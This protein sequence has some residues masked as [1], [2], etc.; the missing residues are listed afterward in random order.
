VLHGATIPTLVPGSVP[1]VLLAGMKTATRRACAT[2][3]NTHRS[4][5]LCM[6]W[7]PAQQQMWWKQGG[8]R[9]PHCLSPSKG[10]QN[11]RRPR[12]C[13]V[14][15]ADDRAAPCLNAQRVLVHRDGGGVG[16]HGKA[17]RIHVGQVGPSE[18]GALLYRPH[19]EVELTARQPSRAIAAVEVRAA[20]DKEGGSRGAHKGKGAR[21]LRTLWQD[22]KRGSL[23]NRCTWSRVRGSRTSTAAGRT[24]PKHQGDCSRHHTCWKSPS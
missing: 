5:E 4:Q 1:R 24:W 16:Q 21:K 6:R 13:Q 9:G 18:Q 2:P 23:A 11:A 8:W 22:A 7:A 12:A 3:T 15:G 14:T 19:G 20:V 10:H 17:R